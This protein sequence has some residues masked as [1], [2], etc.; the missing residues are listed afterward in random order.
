MAT[1]KALRGAP[2]DVVELSGRRVGGGSRVG[3]IVDV[4]GDSR[5]P[6]YR[7]HWEDGHESLLYAGEGIT[8]RKGKAP[9]V[10]RTPM[11]LAPAAEALVRVLVDHD[12]RFELLPHRRTATATAEAR[13]VGVLPQTVAKTVVAR[14]EAGECVRAVVP[15]SRHLDTAKL[16]A[17]IEAPHV[18]VLAEDEL[19]A[20]YPQ[21][22]LGAVPPFGGPAGDTVVVDNELLR[23]DL[24]ELEGGTHETSIRLAPEDLI[25]VADARLADIARM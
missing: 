10:R 25:A 6:R 22:E 17:V 14:T 5:H 20:A 24:V 7:V 21:F 8:I 2:G 4:R 3:E 18:D 23:H 1:I 13:A 15:A 12:V 9:R 19:V 11:T 16:A